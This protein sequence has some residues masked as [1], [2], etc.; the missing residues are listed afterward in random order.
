M[1]SRA[2]GIGES[3]PDLKGLWMSTS[4]ISAQGQNK[5]DLVVPRTQRAAKAACATTEGTPLTTNT[6]VII[7]R[8]FPREPNSMLASSS[9]AHR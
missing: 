5:E 9:S 4:C 3:N 8:P 7:S 2:A 1:P 6:W